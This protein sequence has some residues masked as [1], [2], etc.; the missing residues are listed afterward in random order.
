LEKKTEAMKKPSKFLMLAGVILCAFLPGAAFASECDS[1]CT[2]DETCIAAG[3]YPYVPDM[4]SFSSAICDAWTASG[5]TEKLYLIADE[6]IWDGGYSSDPVYT[7]GSGTSAPIDVFVFDAMYLEYWQT[8]TVPIPASEITD[9]ADFVS[10]ASTALTQEGGS[11]LAL[12]M[13]GCTNHV[14]PQR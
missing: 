5:Q 6:N 11:M 8:Q 9:P 12:P 13:L 3:L 10:Y 4:D 1:I 2:D 7:N 14:L